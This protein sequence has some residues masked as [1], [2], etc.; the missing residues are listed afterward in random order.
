M[1][2]ASATTQYSPPWVPEPNG[3]GTWDILYSC[4]FTL[5][6]C[7]WSAIHLNIPPKGENDWWQFG[8]K[9]KRLVIAVFAPEMVLYSAWQQYYLAERFSKELQNVCRERQG[10]GRDERT[11]WWEDMLDRLWDC[12]LIIFGVEKQHA[13]EKPDTPVAPSPPLWQRVY[14]KLVASRTKPPAL[15][16]KVKRQLAKISL[17]YGFY[18][19]MGGFTVDAGMLYDN[20]ASSTRQHPT[21]TRRLAK[22]LDKSWSAFTAKFGKK[23]SETEEDDTDAKSTL[24][25]DIDGG[26][27]VYVT[28]TPRG[29]IELAQS[30]S[31]D[32]FWQKFFVEQD[33]IRDKSKA[34]S[35]N[36][37]LVSIQVLWALLNSVSRLYLGYSISVLEIHTLVH[38]GCAMIIYGLW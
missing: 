21:R 13:S 7:V 12:S 22:R 6:L 26:D 2:N 23:P 19:V 33:S 8:R 35:L 14:T 29:V 11:T 5:S 32:D 24:S 28:L 36:K 38:A 25:Q 31:W 34:D 3:R 4:I 17:T 18:V 10:Y 27:P 37:M 15:P 20:L 9:T 16:K 1:A 30:M